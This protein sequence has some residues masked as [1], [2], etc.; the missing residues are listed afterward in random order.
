MIFCI[1]IDGTICTNT[2]GDYPNA[3]PFP[4]VIAEVNR[5][6]DAGHEIVLHTA[7]GGTTGIDWRDETE[8][9][10]KKWDMKYH[11]L[12]MG[13]PSADIYIDDKGLNASD[14]RRSGF[15]TTLPIQSDEPGGT[16]R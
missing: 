13:K 12:H 11:A 2:D 5:L 6:Y 15:D 3:I 9:Q 4:H 7:R 8:R 16:T 14:W 1:D 10:L